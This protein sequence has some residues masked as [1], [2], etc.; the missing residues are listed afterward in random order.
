MDSTSNSRSS[1]WIRLLAVVVLAVAAWLMLRL[2]IG[3]LTTVAWV[4]AVVVA[5]AGIFW[6][7][8]VLRR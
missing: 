5:L 7:V 1:L 6:A 4:V 3:V 2:I 8:R